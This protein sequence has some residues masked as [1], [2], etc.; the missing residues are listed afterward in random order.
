MSGAVEGRGAVVT[1]GGRGIGEATARALSAEG[2]RVIVAART[3]S[4]VA[5]VADAIT[6][7]GG[8][9]WGVAC[10][11]TDPVSVDG[12]ADAAEER[13]GQVDILVNNAGIAHSAPVART[14]LDDWRR[15]LEVN[16]TGTFLV[17]RAFLPA[18]M[19][20]GWGR[21]VNVASVAGLAGDRYIS[22]YAASKHA[23]IGFTRSAAVEAAEHGVTVNAVCPAFVDTRITRDSVTRV[24][25]ITG[26][27]EEDVL[28]G[29]LAAYHQTRLLTPDEVARA[30]VDLCR[31]DAGGRNGE[32]VLLDGTAV[33]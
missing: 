27:A 24:A 20:R 33:P 4:E 8:H 13:L 29:I 11:V 15:L 32:A 9:A 12:L 7:S 31:E 25:E 26:R 2:A 21:V 17:T 30:I 1:G 6:K 28:S 22:A 19:E 10:D 23:V 18:M 16:A 14:A 5:D 3:S